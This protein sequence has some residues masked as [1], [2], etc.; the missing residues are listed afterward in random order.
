MVFKNHTA[1]T[2]SSKCQGQAHTLPS[3]VV[4]TLFKISRSLFG[5][6]P[7]MALQIKCKNMER[8]HALTFQRIF[9]SETGVNKVR[10]RRNR[11]DNYQVSETVTISQLCSN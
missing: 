7:C 2:V 3:V 4:C 1:I 6:R 11:R 8:K 5:V 9:L 10:Y